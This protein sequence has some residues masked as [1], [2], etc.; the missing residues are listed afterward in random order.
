M[1]QVECLTR[2]RPHDRPPK[3]V[4]RMI[5]RCRFV[6]LPFSLLAAGIV[7]AWVA[8]ITSVRRVSR[9]GFVLPFQLARSMRFGGL[10]ELAVEID[11]G[12]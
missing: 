7:Y 3:P 6:S 8:T 4:C 11:L 9:L 12:E 5:N 2:R 10:L 1:E